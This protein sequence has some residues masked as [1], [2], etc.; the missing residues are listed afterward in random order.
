M[1]G[2]TPI[3]WSSKQQ[4]EIALSTCEAEYIA[5]STMMRALLPLRALLK[6]LA[7]SLNIEHDEVTKVCAVWEDNNA[8]LKLVNV[9]FPNMTP[10]T[11][12][13]A[14]TTWQ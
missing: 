12:H 4:T 14:I 7:R 3:V 13:I 5:L 2:G 1:I 11:K 10:R 6:L 8:A 9:Q